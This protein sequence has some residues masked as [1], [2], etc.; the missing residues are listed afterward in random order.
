MFRKCRALPTTL[1]HTLMTRQTSVREPRNFRKMLN[2]YCRTRLET[3]FDDEKLVGKAHNVITNFSLC[4]ILRARVEKEERVIRKEK[5]H[6]M[7]RE[8]RARRAVLATCLKPQEVLEVCQ[9]LLGIAGS[10]LRR[11]VREC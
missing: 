11:A 6:C 7:G 10:S 1:H 8:G 4:G 3:E 5:M 2:L 9:L